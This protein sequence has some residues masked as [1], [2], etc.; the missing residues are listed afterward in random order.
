[1]RSK[2]ETEVNQQRMQIEVFRKN[3]FQVKRIFV[4]GPSHHVRL[5]G[6]AVSA[7]T[8]YATPFYSLNID[9]GVNEELMN[10]GEFEVMT[11]EADE[12]EHSIEMHL[13]FIARVMQNNRDFTVVPIL[14]GS[15]SPDKESKYGRIFAKYLSDPSNLFVISSDF[16]HWG[17]RFR[18]T[19]YDDKKGEIHESIKALD[20]AVLFLRYLVNKI[21]VEAP[22]PQQMTRFIFSIYIR[23]RTFSKGVK[24]K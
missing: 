7:C 17:Q 6:C 22:K 20:F 14:V 3:C 10:T 13:P 4:L 5:S 21:I 1:M 15:L 16:C 12:D 9:R 11:L 18:Y 19:Y 23:S 8:K 2:T 24:W